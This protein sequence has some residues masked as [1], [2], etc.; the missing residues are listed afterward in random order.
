MTEIKGILKACKAPVVSVKV[1][2]S[3]MPIMPSKGGPVGPFR[4][5]T[6]AAS[7]VVEMMWYKC[8]CVNSSKL[9]VSWT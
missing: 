9:Q 6:E 5:K 3:P 2:G 4:F 8:F 7:R 1:A